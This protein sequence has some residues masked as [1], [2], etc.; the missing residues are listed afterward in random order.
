MR[1]LNL[2]VR[3]Q[4]ARRGFTLVELL[5]VIGI[6][7]LLI[8]ILLPALGKARD[9]ATK[10]KCAANLRGIGVAVH[11]YASDTKN[12]VTHMWNIPVYGYGGGDLFYG[13]NALFKAR[14][15]KST[16]SLWCPADPDGIG[17]SLEAGNLPWRAGYMARPF[18]DI[19]LPAIYAGTQY[20][21][22]PT[23]MSAGGTS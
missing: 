17:V 11:M 9:S 1:H 5:V 14:Y 4:C 15:L 13:E 23:V 10:I 21:L 8:S 19:N 22:P 20:T 6:I 7:A 16:Q 12:F 3:R 2:Q 18:K